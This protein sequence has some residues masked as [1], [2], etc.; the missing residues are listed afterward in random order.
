M[1]VAEYISGKLLT[2][3]SEAGFVYHIVQM[4]E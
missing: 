2:A 3:K 4:S 1:P